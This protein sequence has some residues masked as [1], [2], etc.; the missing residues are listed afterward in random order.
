MQVLDYGLQV[1]SLEFLGI[2]EFLVHR[3]G[4]GRILV[5]DLQVQ[6]IR[7]PARIRWGTGHSVTARAMR[8]R[9]FGLG[10]YVGLLF[11]GVNTGSRSLGFVGW[12]FE[13]PLDL[14][15]IHYSTPDLAICTIDC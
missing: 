4:Q 14:V 1:K 9:A 7:P 3:I 2:I 10:Q 15:D 5:K 6:L 12:Q 8:Y 13:S 11:S